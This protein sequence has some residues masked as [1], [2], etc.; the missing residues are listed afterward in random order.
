MLLMVEK[1]I[2]WEICHAIHRS[3][4]AKNKYMKKYNKDHDSSYIMYLDANNL[5]IWA[6]SQK[7]PVNSFKWKRNASKFSEGFM[8][9]YD[10]NSNKGYILEVDIEYP[11]RLHNLHNDLT[12]LPE[13][14]KINKCN[15]LICNLYDIQQYVVHIRA[16]K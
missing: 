7:L 10:E 16:L 3:V 15:K 12:F 13:R 2:K 5:Y 1:G 9:N 8:K 4:K 6:M 11:K 14:M